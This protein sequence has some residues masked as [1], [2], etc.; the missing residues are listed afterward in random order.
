[1]KTDQIEIIE[2]KAQKLIQEFGK[3]NLIKIKEISETKP[4][5]KKI[6]KKLRSKTEIM[7]KL[8]KKLKQ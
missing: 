1:M 5:F 6:L 2:S 8:P 4:E 3:L 7:M